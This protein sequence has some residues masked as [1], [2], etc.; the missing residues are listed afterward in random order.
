MLP[1]FYTQ[2]GVPPDSYYAYLDE[3]KRRLRLNKMLEEAEQ[4]SRLEAEKYQRRQAAEAEKKRREVDERNRQQ[5]EALT[6]R[7]RQEEEARQRQIQLIEEEERRK[8]QQEVQRLQD[9]T[10]RKRQLLVTVVG[11]LILCVA[12]ALGIK[13]ISLLTSK[14]EGMLHSEKKRFVTWCAPGRYYANKVKGFITSSRGMSKLS[15][16]PEVCYQCSA[17]TSSFSSAGS[18]VCMPCMS[19]SISS[20]GSHQCSKCPAG[21]YSDATLTSC[22]A[23][24][25]G[26]FSIEGSGMCSPCAA[27][28]ASKAASS[29]GL[30]CWILQCSKLC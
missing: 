1:W 24:P 29:H 4:E 25:A 17:G 10:R 16:G 18:W 26:M 9:E 28:T 22:K 27:G 5:A 15:W 8:K 30:S 6:I 21:T 19:G 3:K 7:R 23:C 2:G 20:K 11:S 13:L 14:L 12:V